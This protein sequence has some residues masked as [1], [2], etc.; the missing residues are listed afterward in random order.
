MWKLNNEYFQKQI[1]YFLATFDN[2][3][4]ILVK[5]YA[6][7]FSNPRKFTEVFGFQ[8]CS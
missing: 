6:K 4:Y 1:T 8:S 3:M 2:V 7:L 5:Q